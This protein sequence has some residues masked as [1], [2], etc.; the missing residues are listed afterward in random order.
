MSEKSKKLREERANL[1][2]QSRELVDRVDNEKREMNAEER[3][4]YTKW[5]A[6]QEDLKVK[7]EQEEKLEAAEKEMRAQVGTETRPDPQGDGSNKKPGANRSVVESDEYREAYEK[8]MVSGDDA[9]ARSMSVGSITQA[10]ILVTPVQLVDKFLKAVD[11]QLFIRQKAGEKFKLTQALKIQI[12]ELTNDPDEPETVTEL[13]TGSEETSMAVGARFL[14]PHPKARSFKL[15]RDIIRMAMINVPEFVINRLAYMF[16]VHWE[17]KFLLGT[18]FQEPLGVFTA[19]S[20]GIPT[21]RDVLSGSTTGPTFDG[22]KACKYSLKDAHREKS[23]WTFHRNLLE[24]LSKIKDGEGRYQWQDS[25]KEGEPDMLLG[26]PVRSSEYCPNTNTTG[27]YVGILANWEYFWI[28]DAYDM[29]ITPLYE[30]SARTNQVEYHARQAS[31]GRPV[32]AE[33]FA[34]VINQ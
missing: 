10:G 16:A 33:A 20:L 19:S 24:H 14:E 7:I 13:Q 27:Q 3:G 22:L 9:E 5:F 25:V 11:N 12:P 34:R 28:A 2:S 17:K 32:L 18:G 30:M 31:D 8:F 1:I 15:S 6:A 29:E 23:D 4:S 21:S 26:R